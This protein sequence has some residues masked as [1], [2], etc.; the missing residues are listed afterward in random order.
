MRRALFRRRLPEPI[1]PAEVDLRDLSI[2]RHSFAVTLAAVRGIPLHEA[3]KLVDEISDSM[4]RDRARATK[5]PEA[6]HGLA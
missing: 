3:R 4:E 2:P 6:S 5:P 1:V